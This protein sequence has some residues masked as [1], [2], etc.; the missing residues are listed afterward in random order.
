MADYYYS[1]SVAT[2]L[3]DSVDDIYGRLAQAASTVSG[4]QGPAWSVQISTLKAAL[5]GAPN[6]DRLYLEFAVPRLGKRIDAVLVS[7]HA[8]FVLEFKIGATEYIASALDQVWDYALDL[9]NFHETSHAATIVPVLVATDAVSSRKEAMVAYP[10]GVFAPV[11][12]NAADLSDLISEVRLTVSGA[13]L[14]RAKWEA[15]NYRPTPTIIEAAAALYAGHSVKEIS[16]SGAEEK[17]LTATTDAVLRLI[18]SAREANEKVICFVTGVPGAGKTLV[19]L[20]IATRHAEGDDAHA[21]YLSG[22]GPLVQVLTE[23]LARDEVTRSGRGIGE[24]RRLVSKFIQS[25]HHYRDAYL[26]NT[27]APFDRVAIFDEAQRA[28]DWEQT[29]NFMRRRRGIQDFGFSEPEYLVSCLERHQGW[30]VI[31]CLV[32]GG[33]EINRGEVGISEWLKATMAI[34]DKWR[35]HISPEL[36]SSPYFVKLDEK[37]SDLVRFDGDLHLSVSMRSFRASKVSYLVDALIAIEAEEASRLFAEVRENYPL[38][39]TRSV[40]RAR[41]WLRGKSRGSE[42][43]G[44]LVSSSALRLKPCAIDVRAPIDPVNWFLGPKEDVRSSHYLEDAATEFQVQGLEVDWAGV[45]WDGDLRHS[46]G[47]WQHMSFKGT[48][49]E[50]VVKPDRRR[51]LENAYRVLLT[52]ARQGLVIVVP[53]GNDKDPTRARHLYDGTYEYLKSVG[54]PELS[55]PVQG[56]LACNL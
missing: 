36:S 53:E 11:I 16:R 50:R 29:A 17:N 23:A 24:S 44:L 8:L 9:K 43:H 26:Q 21:V 1:A 55:G 13:W 38:F 51:Y 48:R 18:E 14:D 33:Q 31:V 35:V 3:E 49:W 5:H 15:G 25:V 6:E 19:G 40:E 2:F 32:G 37:K 56:P 10:D 30:A 28:W 47:E 46:A 39:I 42:R 45:V 34:P 54:I 27:T 41:H 7:E 4:Y 22:N 12:S 52:R 20:D